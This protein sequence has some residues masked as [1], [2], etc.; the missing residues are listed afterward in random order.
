MLRISYKCRLDIYILY[1]S[2]CR[3][4]DI[5]IILMFSACHLYNTRMARAPGSGPFTVLWKVK[6]YYIT[7]IYVLYISYKLLVGYK[8]SLLYVFSLCSLYIMVWE[9]SNSMLLMLDLLWAQICCWE[10]E[11]FAMLSMLRYQ[12]ISNLCKVSLWSLAFNVLVSTNLC[13]VSVWYFAFNVWSNTHYF[14]LFLH[15]VSFSL[16]GV[17][18]TLYFIF[19]EVILFV[20]FLKR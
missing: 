4:Y 7:S 13:R 20:H 12:Q 19:K 5:C 18:G 16:S 1:I 11:L 15:S 9:F 17:R 10:F 14:Y 8:I 6:N 3:Q 2:I